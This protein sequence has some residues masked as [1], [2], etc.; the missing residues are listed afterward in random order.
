[1]NAISSI[2]LSGMNAAQ[3]RLQSS[4][5]NIANLNTQ[6][7]QRQEVTQSALA[8]GG[9]RAELSRADSIGANL[10]TDMVQ[11]LQAK[12]IFLVNLSV[13]K[14]SNAVLGSLLDTLA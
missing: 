10:E 12:N 2:S 7:F 3:T 9:T 8:E 5:H 4:A 11:Q 1:M 13:F 14:T 6:S